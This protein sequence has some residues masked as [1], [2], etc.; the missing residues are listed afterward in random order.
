MSTCCA[1]LDIKSAFDAAWHP[2]I[3]SGLIKKKCPLSLVKLIQSFLKSRTG[4]MKSSV[5]LLIDILLG[6]PQGSILSPFLWNILLEELLKLSFPFLFLIIAYADDIVLCTF[7]SDLTVAQANLQAMCVAVESW[8]RDVKLSFNALKTIFMLFTCLR[9]PPPL[10]ITMGGLSIQT[11]SQCKY[12]GITID[13]KLNWSAHIELKCVA[14]K[15]LL[16][17]ISKCCRLTW[18]LSRKTLSLLYKTVFLPTLLYNCSVWASAI[19]KKKI[20][21]LLLS[22][23]RPY[24]L[25]IARLYKSTST[26]AAL[27]LANIVPLD[28]KILEIVTKRALVT[29]VLPFSSLRLVTES[30]DFINNTPAPRNISL[31][32]HHARLLHSETCKRWN[33]QWNLS[34]TSGQSKRFFNSIESSSVL[35]N[36][37]LPFFIPRVVSGH[38]SLNAYLCK[39]GKIPSAACICSHPV[40]SLDHLLFEC[41]KYDKIRCSLVS[42]ASAYDLP[43]PFPLCIFAQFKPLWVAFC[44]FL[45][46]SKRFI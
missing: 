32:F 9:T 15:K 27:V 43:W 25:A 14:A 20:V 7:D 45:V 10:S 41:T 21:K 16:F 5:S 28:L 8:G 39:I 23:Q 18:G 4:R 26:S 37:N 46:A 34:V 35:N 1:F 33:L 17:F 24:A 2:K 19:S 36:N 6:C 29:N 31:K 42:A 11:S 13:A 12:L 40:E 30:I 22:T 3:L 44:N 38:C